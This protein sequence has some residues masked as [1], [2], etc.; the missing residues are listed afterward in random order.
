MFIRHSNS[1]EQQAFPFYRRGRKLSL[2]AT[3]VNTVSCVTLRAGNPGSKF[4]YLAY[5]CGTGRPRHV[6]HGATEACDASAVHARFPD[7]VA[8]VVSEAGVC[9]TAWAALPLRHGRV[10]A[11]EHG[12]S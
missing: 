11:G 4:Y 6:P 8:D 10:L 2:V 9:D 3:Q 12:T 7:V 5:A 1:T